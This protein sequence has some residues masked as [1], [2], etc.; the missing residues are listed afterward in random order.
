M[1]RRG[2][3]VAR[4][5]NDL[6][7][8]MVAWATLTQTW[9]ALCQPGQARIPLQEALALAERIPIKYWSVRPWSWLVSNRALSGDWESAY[10]AALQVS[11]L[12][13]T[14]Q[15]PHVFFDLFRSAET[16]ALV[17]QGDSVR[18]RRDMQRLEEY[19]RPERQHRR[20]RLVLL[21]M[22]AVLAHHEGQTEAALLQLEE[23]LRLAEEMQLPGEQWQML[24]TLWPLYQRRNTP[25]D[26]LRAKQVRGRAN[27]I[28]HS[29]AEAIHDAA[30]REAFLAGAMRQISDSPTW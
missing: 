6:Y 5:S 15:V 24:A 4:A 11:H 21:R 1:A 22:Q 7:T 18:A 19:L 17:R 20:Y 27:A 29:L 3:E 10:A 26:A 16:A 23:A 8:Q 25:E 30:L 9:H 28:I 13:E 14:L 12:R 2:V